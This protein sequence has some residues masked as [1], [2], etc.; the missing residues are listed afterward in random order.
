[1]LFAKDDH[2]QDP[3]TQRI[4]GAA[5]E[6]HRQMGPGLLEHVYE[7]ALC[8]EFVQSGLAFVCQQPI[9]VHYKGVLLDCAFRADIIVEN[10]IILELK[11]VDRVTPI[12]EAT[13][14]TYMKLTNI[15]R[16]L[17]INFN[18]L[19]VKDGIQRFVL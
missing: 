11:A 9:P 7:Q 14:L 18:V 12:H 2:A 19:L 16:S 17:L 1:M 4:I 3:L 8:Y 5:I 6:V 13:L 15:R 10:Q